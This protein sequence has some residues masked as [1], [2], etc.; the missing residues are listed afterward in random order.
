[1]VQVIEPKPNVYPEYYLIEVE[2]FEDVIKEDIDEWIYFFKNE[3]I[4]D[5]FHSKNIQIAKEKLRLLKMSEKERKAYEKYLMLLAS[6]RDAIATARTEGE[7][8][9]EIRGKIKGK[10]EGKIDSLLEILEELGPVPS[11]LEEKIRKQTDL[12]ILKKWLKMA[13][14]TNSIEEFIQNISA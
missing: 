10:I 6:E 1:V 4:K 12:E 7:I 14:K 5:D 11:S 9:G 8:R 2:R 13:V 3:E